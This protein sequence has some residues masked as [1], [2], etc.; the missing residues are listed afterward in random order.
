MRA[1]NI[2]LSD[3]NTH[4]QAAVT[5]TARHLLVLAGAGS[6]KTRVLV[7]RIA[8][9]VQSQGL[10]PHQILA[11]TFTNKA[12]KEMR[13]R[14]EGILGGSA[15]HLWVGTF[16]GIAHRLLR[17]H[18]QAANLNENFQILDSDDQQRLVKRVIK[19]LDLDEERWQPKA[20]QWY[21]N[22]Q[23]DEGLRPHQLTPQDKFSA[24]Q[25]QIYQLYEEAC[26][27]GGMID[28]ADLLLRAYEL[29]QQHPDILF[30]YQQRFRHMLV[31][32][33][34]DTNTIQY[35]WLKALAGKTVDVTIVG[36]DDQ[37]I[38][39]W[40]GA[41]IENIQ[42]FDRDFP[43][44]ELVRLEQNYRSTDNILKAANA[45][46]ANNG[47]RLGKQ[48][49]TEDG[50]GEPI[51]LYAAFNETEEAR[52][53]VSVIKQQVDGGCR[54]HDIAILYRSNAQSR[55]IEEALL[56]ARI[57]YRIYG[58]FR[59]F[60]RLEIKNAMAY[61]RLM[62]NHQDDA[63]FER[64]VNVPGRGIGETT[65]AEIR[66]QSRQLQ[67]PLWQTAQ[68]MVTHSLIPS[69]ARTALAGFLDLIAN[70]KQS[71]ESLP[72]SA[73]VELAIAR[74]GLLPF[75]EKEK[76]EKARARIDN[77]KELVN[78]AQEFN[79]VFNDPRLSEDLSAEGANPSEDQNRNDTLDRYHRSALAEFLDH[80]ALESGEL[81]ANEF[82]DCVQLMTLHSAKGLEFPHVFLVGVEEGLFPSPMA[83]DQGERLEEERRLCYVGI[84]RA[85]KKLTLTY[86]ES[87]RVFG[88]DKRHT[89]SR[90][91]R[92][93]PSG[94]LQEA[95]PQIAVSRPLYGRMPIAPSASKRTPIFAA[96]EQ[97]THGLSLGQRVQH[98]KFGEGTVLNF[99]GSGDHSRVQVNF[100]AQGS[101]WL[102][103]QYAQLQPA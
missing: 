85:M 56:R 15:R 13:G 12:S 62:H 38:Y 42:Q 45:V 81:Q 5:S 99:E 34:Q 103:V 7:Q 14:I 8:W 76:G 19:Q 84:T 33:F 71:C 64:I 47:S 25:A 75:Y 24:T 80:T 77:L 91:V 61:L 35:Q 50:E 18:W 72:L 4:Q 30:H 86:A 17:T 70:L 96:S 10:S 55:V 93:I 57:P 74:S 16:H 41:K 79:G 98:K 95:R 65:I 58:G 102:V 60:D 90:F 21:I 92:E 94:L 27:R 51:D 11:V 88:Q 22:Q 82:E 32:E 68:A 66:E 26:Q 6:G 43:G 20:L 73:Q 59:F 36:D 97:P 31:D 44:G 49:W 29:W 89:V 67:L 63:A 9:L 37:S 3:L 28:F 40:R 78:A 48:L 54:H 101:K 87:R 23:K 39:G 46:I 100:K 2:L 52:Y 83:L 53:V 69:R 1:M